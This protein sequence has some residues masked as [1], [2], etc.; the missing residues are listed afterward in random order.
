M[1][2][3]PIALSCAMLLG[4]TLYTA[5]NLQAAPPTPP[6]T[7]PATQPAHAGL[8]RQLIVDLKLTENQRK[9]LKA[10]II[11]FHEKMAAWRE[12]HKPQLQ[13]LREEF[14]AAREAKDHDKVLAVAK[15]FRTLWETAPHVKDILPEIKKVLTPEQVE[16]VKERLEKWREEHAGGLRLYLQHHRASAPAT[17]PAAN[18]H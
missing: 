7:A 17:Q 5:S 4:T 15:E 2:L 1:K 3:S 13:K 18:K 12:T 9:E 16:L 11:P 6:T 14:K 8:F 10:I